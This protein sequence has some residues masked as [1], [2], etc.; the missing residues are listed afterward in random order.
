MNLYRVLALTI[1]AE[2]AADRSDVR[3]PGTFLPALIDELSLLTPGAI[4]ERAKV[5]VLLL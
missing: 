1:A 5:E 4:V 3:G 2:H